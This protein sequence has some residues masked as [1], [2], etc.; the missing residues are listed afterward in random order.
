MFLIINAMLNAQRH[1]AYQ[2]VYEVLQTKLFLLLKYNAFNVY[3]S[4]KAM[5]NIF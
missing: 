3:E 2:I 1:D 4:K 5:S